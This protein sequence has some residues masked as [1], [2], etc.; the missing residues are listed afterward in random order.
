MAYLRGTGRNIGS[1]IKK[2]EEVNT[3]LTQSPQLLLQMEQSSTGKILKVRKKLSQDHSIQSLSLF[4]RQS[5]GGLGFLSIP[6]LT[7]GK[8][9]WESDPGL[10]CAEVVG[11]L[12][13]PS[14]VCVLLTS[15]CQ[16]SEIS[17]MTGCLMALRD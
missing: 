8:R 6:A 9:N 13:G 7:L 4:E 16:Q 11:H 10:F 14:L 15:L 12:C 17:T 3:L 5:L 1:E 2:E